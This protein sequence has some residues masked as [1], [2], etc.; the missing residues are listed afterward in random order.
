MKRLI[1]HLCRLGIRKYKSHLR[2]N[3][4]WGHRL[5]VGLIHIQK[6]TIFNQ[7]DIFK[8]YRENYIKYGI[9]TIGFFIKLL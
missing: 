3:R 1:P 8:Q 7:S 6:V 9:I 4:H 5:H 2:G